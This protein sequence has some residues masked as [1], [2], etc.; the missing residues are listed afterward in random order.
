MI[1]DREFRAWFALT[2]IEMVKSIRDGG[3]RFTEEDSLLK[4]EA[5]EMVCSGLQ[6]AH[7]MGLC[8]LREVLKD[9]TGKVTE[10]VFELRL[11][12]AG[13]EFVKGAAPVVQLDSN[14]TASLRASLERTAATGDGSGPM[15]NG[16]GEVVGKKS[17][18][19]SQ[20]QIL[21]QAREVLRRMDEEDLARS[22]PH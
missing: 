14:E 6:L 18:F 15:I 17:D 12:P 13:E 21:D 10:V 16:R 22:R 2:S 7:E 9:R 3:R 1:G 4:G 11:T 19:M 20:Q 5:F 8:R